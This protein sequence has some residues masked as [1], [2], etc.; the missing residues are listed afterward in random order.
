MERIEQI[1]ECSFN[2]FYTMPLSM[3]EAF[4]KKEI[5]DDPDVQQFLDD[6]YYVDDWRKC[7]IPECL[8]PYIDEE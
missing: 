1:S 5:H 8:K 6:V 4:D 7:K 2:P 3:L